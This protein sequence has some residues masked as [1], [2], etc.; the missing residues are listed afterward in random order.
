MKKVCVCLCMIMLCSVA[1]SLSILI[2]PNDLDRFSAE[3]TTRL[4]TEL[5][6]PEKLKQF[7][8]K[9]VVNYDD[10][11]IENKVMPRFKEKFGV[12]D[13]AVASA[14]MSLCRDA[15]KGD[16]DAPRFRN[17]YHWLQVEKVAVKDEETKRFLLEAV[18]DNSKSNG[19]RWLATWL[20]FPCASA[21]EVKDFYIWLLDE[22]NQT[23]EFKGEHTCGAVNIAYPSAD[24]MKKEVFFTAICVMTTQ[25]ENSLDSSALRGTL[26]MMF[27]DPYRRSDQG[28]ALL[29]RLY[30]Q[31]ADPEHGGEAKTELRML[32]SFSL[33]GFIARD[34]RENPKDVKWLRER[35]NAILRQTPYEL[36]AKEFKQKFDVTDEVLEILLI[37]IY[38]MSPLKTGRRSKDANGDTIAAHARYDEETQIRV[39]SKWLGICAGAEGKKILWDIAIDKDT[40]NL[41]CDVVAA[42]LNRADAQ[43]ARDALVRFLITDKRAD[44]DKFNLY[45]RALAAYDGA[46]D[47]LKREA[48]FASLAVALAREEHRGAFSGIEK[49]LVQRSKEYKE[50]N[51]RFIMLRDTND[52][53]GMTDDELELF[54]VE[55][56]LFASL[57]KLPSVSTSLT[58]LMAR[59]FRKPPEIKK[60]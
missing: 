11:D 10:M 23:G 55:V 58:E 6:D 32:L 8:A 21:Q 27:R 28:L 48:I 24:E 53:Q 2:T 42:Y 59:D 46:G 3:E 16:D 19:V 33:P 22:K 52:R 37:D 30:E 49:Q 20:Y 9:E 54:G 15:L 35:L 51:E 38:R 29:K 36:T 25:T 45:S 7:L 56:D 18:K 17:L 39:L 60:E 34:F 43:E 44:E 31:R 1:E 47:D 40:K 4:R 26:D 12:G 50:L 41:L 57:K 5:K 13:E 14:L